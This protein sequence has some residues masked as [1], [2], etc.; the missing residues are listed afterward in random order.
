MQI[1][2]FIFNFIYSFNVFLQKTL[3]GAFI[4]LWVTG[5]F[6]C[7]LLVV[8]KKGVPA[9]LGMAV[10]FF[11]GIFQ[12]FPDGRAGDKFYMGVHGTV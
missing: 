5:L 12:Y 11:S 2:Q 1:K 10:Q 9:C 7:V 6:W 8:A 4:L 3:I